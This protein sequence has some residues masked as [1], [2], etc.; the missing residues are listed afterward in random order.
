[1]RDSDDEEKPK[2]KNRGNW[3]PNYLIDPREMAKV[4][5]LL[6]WLP[7]DIM[8][9][10]F[11]N[12]VGTRNIEMTRR[13]QLRENRLYEMGR[14]SITLPGVPSTLILPTDYYFY[15]P[16]YGPGY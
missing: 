15:K 10:I 1:M 5:T 11:D 3:D 12:L 16:R 7:G 13:K 8:R 4:L 6:V 14:V 9:K 2:K